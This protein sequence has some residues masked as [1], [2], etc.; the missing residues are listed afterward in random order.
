MGMTLLPYVFRLWQSS[1]PCG[2]MTERPNLLLAV[3][4]KLFS[5]LRC[6][7][8]FLEAICSLPWHPKQ[9]AQ[10]IKSARRISECREAP[11]LL[12]VSSTQDNLPLNTPKLI[13][14]NLNYIC[15]IFSL[16]HI[17]LVRSRSHARGKDYICSGHKGG[18]DYQGYFKI[19]LLSITYRKS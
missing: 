3:S 1:F 17:V 9:T 14:W 6:Q 15:K 4:W 12:K 10:F 8:W 13:I 18:R 2:F 16:C 11:V 7:P 5:G 19:C